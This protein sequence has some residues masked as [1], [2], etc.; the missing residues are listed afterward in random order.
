M[1][2]RAGRS[3]GVALAVSLAA[4]VALMAIVSLA[5]APPPPE[6][7][8]P[9]EFEVV[10]V[11]VP[12]PPPEPEPEPEPEPVFAPPPKPAPLMK[13]VAKAEPKHEPPPPPPP[14]APPPPE[15]KSPPAPIR[16]GVSLSSTTEGGGFAVGT[17]SSL[18]GKSPDKAAAPSDAPHESA[19]EAKAPYVPYSQ[20]STLPMPI[21]R[22]HPKYP[23]EMRE[24]RIEGQVIVE[25]RIDEQGKPSRVRV[26]RSLGKA[27]DD[28]AVDSMKKTRFKP[29]TVRGEPV[30]TDL[31]LTYTFL[32]E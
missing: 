25:A 18:Y 30:S 13:P 23:P 24:S 14:N 21:T 11:P 8:E 28:L 6:E 27:F 2:R 5:P 3:F 1:E 7:N 29:A 20:L 10:Q 12:P 15:T 32:L 17:G 22:V 16:I 4:H 31:R 19:G 9:V 26:I